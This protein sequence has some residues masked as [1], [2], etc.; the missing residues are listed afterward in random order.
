MAAMAMSDSG[1]SSLLP[2]SAAG[3]QAD[4]I[5]EDLSIF[6]AQLGRTVAALGRYLV[7]SRWRLHTASGCLACI[8]NTLLSGGD[9]VSAK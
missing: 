2:L 4:D 1:T 5:C 7:H 6:R 8:F 9:K 3:T